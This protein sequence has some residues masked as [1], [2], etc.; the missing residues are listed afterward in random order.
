M[1]R[2][3]RQRAGASE[4]DLARADNLK[5]DKSSHEIGWPHF[6]RNGN[7]ICNC[8]H[9]IGPSGCICNSGCAGIG[10]VNCPNGSEKVT[11]PDVLRGIGSA[12][13]A[14]NNNG[15]RHPTT[16]SARNVEKQAG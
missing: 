2:A 6:A 4:L 11:W 9:C 14:S 13:S 10:H 5:K 3:Y 8:K 15:Q 7:C 1:T 16:S 12:A